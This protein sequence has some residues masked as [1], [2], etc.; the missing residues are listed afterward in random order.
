MGGYAV[1]I[2]ALLTAMESGATPGW[3]VVS[4]VLLATLGGGFLVGFAFPLANSLQLGSSAQAGQTA[5]LLYGADLLGACAGSLLFSIYFLP[6][7]GV[8]ETSFVVAVL[9]LVGCVAML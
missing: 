9:S 5:G 6:L 4:A 3:L 1:L 2:P 8:W 7:L